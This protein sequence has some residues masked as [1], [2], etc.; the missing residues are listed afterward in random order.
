MD[1]AG[2]LFGLSWPIVNMPISTATPLIMH[3]DLNSAF[4]MAEQQANPLLRGKPIGITNRASS[5]A[6]C[7]TASYEAKRLGVGIG[8][9]MKEARLRAPG[10]VMVESDPAKYKYINSKMRHIFE[11]YS[12]RAYMKSVDEGIIDFHGMSGILK[13]RSLNDIAAEIKDRVREEIGD[14]MTVNIGIGQN[15]WLAKL[16][17]GFLKPDGLYCI[18]HNNMEMVYGLLRLEELPYIKRRNRLRLNEADIF[19]PLEFLGAPESVLSKRVFRSVM[20]YHWYLNLRGYET[21]L[22]ANTVRSV[23]RSYVLEHRT[24]DLEEI[25]RLLYK[26]SIKLARR[27]RMMGLAAR[28]LRLSF[29]YIDPMSSSGLGDM[30]EN[31]LYQEAVWRSDRIYE[32]ACELKARMPIGRVLTALRITS[33]KLE[34]I[35]FDQL[36][37]YD[38]AD[39]RRGRLEVAMNAVND[40]YGEMILSPASAMGVL[41][42]MED[43]VPFGSVRYF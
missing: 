3:V 32:R 6:I 34:T 11:S 33:Y 25:R 13:G 24:A 4:A 39:T 36:S 1:S 27:L 28:G 20:G 5:S 42:P 30:S 38:S 22:D 37:L 31:S 12:P 35:L 8:T 26:A 16:A 19:T 23:G 17:A 15:R 9:R 40:R 14:H 10:F 29:S 41:N 7:I 43:K 21:D 18:D 2:D